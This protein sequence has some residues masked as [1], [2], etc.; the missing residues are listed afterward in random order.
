MHENTE[1]GNSVSS[2]ISDAFT[3]GG[4]NVSMKIAYAANGPDVQP[5]VLQ[6]KEKNPDVVIFISYTRMRS[7]TPRR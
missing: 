1:Y 3:K 7:S 6:L 2:V 5:Q 4:L